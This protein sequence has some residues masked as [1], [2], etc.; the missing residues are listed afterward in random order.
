[1][2]HI[3]DAARHD[4]SLCQ[5]VVDG[6][7]DPVRISDGFSLAVR[8]TTDVPYLSKQS[9]RSVFY[10]LILPETHLFWHHAVNVLDPVDISDTMCSLLP[11]LLPPPIARMVYRI[12]NGFPLT[13]TIAISSAPHAPFVE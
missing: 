3:L 8:T 9:S 5:D 7:R 11:Q 12:L 2:F 1:M 4:F 6:G 10:P 13:N